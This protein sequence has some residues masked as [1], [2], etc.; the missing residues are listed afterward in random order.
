MWVV[1]IYISHALF[2][3]VLVFLFVCL[4]AFYLQVGFGR[5]VCLFAFLFFLLV[6]QF[7]ISKFAY[8]C[9]DV[10]FVCMFVCLFVFLLACLLGYLFACFCVFSPCFFCFFVAFAVDFV[11][12][13]PLSM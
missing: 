4:G 13:E 9:V 2:I 6:W 8:L 3:C 7:F 1:L 5:S 10:L 12:F 11:V